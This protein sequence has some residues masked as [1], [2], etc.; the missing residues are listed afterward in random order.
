MSKAKAANNNDIDFAAKELA[1]KT[2]RNNIITGAYALFAIFV[3]IYVSWGSYQ[4]KKATDPE[5]LAAL[6]SYQIEQ[7]MMPQSREQIDRFLLENLPE[8]FDQMLVNAEDG[9]PELRESLTNELIRTATRDLERMQQDSIIAFEMLL[10]QNDADIRAAIASLEDDEEKDALKETIKTIIHTQYNEYIR[11]DA[12]QI[13]GEFKSFANRYGYL[14]RTPVEN[15]T[16]KELEQRRAVLLL[17][18]VM[19][20]ADEGGQLNGLLKPLSDTL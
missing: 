8:I 6:T 9:L 10:D 20:Q 15:L 2:R 4:L 5:L 18:A 12:Q 19:Q 3:V 13:V 17:M 7:S 14:L 11:D 1:D 16:L